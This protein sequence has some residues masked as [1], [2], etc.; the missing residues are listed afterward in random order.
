M[1]RRLIVQKYGGSSV[2]DPERIKS[3]AQRVIDSKRKGDKI[4]VVLSA[5]GD[6]TDELIKLAYQINE[7][8]A[9][10]ELDMLIST[11]EQV[12]VALLAMAIHKYGY[13]AIS[14]TGA[15]VGIV[16]DGSHTKARILDINSQRIE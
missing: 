4:V 16:T 12:A 14:F 10:R 6:T 15:Q 5:L 3:V 13:K 8:P 2:A 1:K 11:G 9:E 7:E